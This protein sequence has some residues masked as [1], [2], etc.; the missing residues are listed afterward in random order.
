[1]G[2]KRKLSLRPGVITPTFWV[3]RRM[4]RIRGTALDPF[5]R[6]RVRRV[7][8]RM[9]ENYSSAVESSLAVLSA[10]RYDLAVELAGLPEIVRG[11]EEIKLRNVEEFDRRLKELTD[12]LKGRA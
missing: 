10:E 7:E 11:Y 1:M 5:G 6:A 4:R 8:R 9:I 3:L 2:L 12:H